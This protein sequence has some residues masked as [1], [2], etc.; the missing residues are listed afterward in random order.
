M[1][2][3]VFT[4]PRRVSC[5]EPWLCVIRL[6]DW[7]L[8]I[9]LTLCV[10]NFLWRRLS[11]L[12]TPRC[13]LTL[14]MTT[15]C[16]RDVDQTRTLLQLCVHRYFVS[17]G[18][19]NTGLFQRGLSCSYGP[20]G[21]ELRR[22][23]LEQWWSSVSR[24]TAQVFGIKTLSSSSSLDTDTD[25]PGPQLRVVNYEN[26]KQI[27]EEKD[28]SKELLTEKLQMLLQR[29]PTVKT[30]LFQGTTLH[31][32][33]QFQPSFLFK[34]YYTHSACQSIMQVVV[35]WMTVIFKFV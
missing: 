9:M 20:L 3:R 21:M 26:V 11:A 24:S 8:L 16:D 10:T 31:H 34:M 18:D 6:S 35:L 4:P 12:G 19:V 14:Q 28:L 13:S 32:T 5:F 23:L 33:K 17:P 1:S 22:N 7:E 15:S 25:R 27:L 2:R 29:S 30:N